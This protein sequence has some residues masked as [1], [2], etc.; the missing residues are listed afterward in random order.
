MG[1]V[2]AAG[3][4]TPS[5]HSEGVCLSPANFRASDDLTEVEWNRW[6]HPRP[7]N[8]RLVW[9]SLLPAISVQ[10]LWFAWDLEDV[11]LNL[12]SMVLGLVCREVPVLWWKAWLRRLFQRWNLH[13]FFPFELVY[14]WQ[15][16]GTLSS[17]KTG[18]G[19]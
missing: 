15:S 18:G 14:D 7:P 6:V 17:V 12:R 16:S 3:T 19:F 4:P 5:V 13:L 8:A 2:L 10:C 1:G 9:Q 11:L